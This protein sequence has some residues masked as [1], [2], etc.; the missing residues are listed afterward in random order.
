M[1][2]EGSVLNRTTVEDMFQRLIEL[3][4]RPYNGTLYFG[5]EL[6]APVTLCPP[7]A[8]YKEVRDF[9]TIEAKVSKE[10]FIKGM[11]SMSECCPVTGLIMTSF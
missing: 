2:N 4:Y 1:I 11:L 7:P 6:S 8:S 9:E 5:K 10:I 3:R